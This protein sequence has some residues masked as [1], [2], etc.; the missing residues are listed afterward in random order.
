MS[1]VYSD[2]DGVEPVSAS[3]GEA[4]TN[5]ANY[6]TVSGC[7]VTY[8]GANMTFD[9]AAGMITHNGTVLNVAAQAG[10]GP[11]VADPDDPRW[12]WIGLDNTGSVVMV[13][14]TPAAS[15]TVP[16]LGDY[17]E[18]ALVLVT[19]AATIANDLTYKLDKRVMMT[20]E[21]LPDAWLPLYP[22]AAGAAQ[23]ALGASLGYLIPMRPFDRRVT[24]TEL[25][26]TLGGST[27]T[28]DVGIYS[29]TDYVTFT[30]VAST[31][32]L[33][34]PG[35]DNQHLNITDTVLDPG[36]VYYTAIS[37]SG[38][39][40]TIASLVG[41]AMPTGVDGSTAGYAY[42]RLGEDSHPLPATMTG[43]TTENA[44]NPLIAGV[45]SGGRPWT[46]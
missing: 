37:F 30:R 36:T 9:V 19:A 13:A 14:G 41:T 33:A 2:Q 8:S 5:I 6:N 22:P 44:D 7:A 23:S 31:G 35:T 43:M 18:I 29:T 24:I 15:P 28:I 4:A 1:R 26:V 32:S 42:V 12:T 17:V 16:V 20:Y 10:E 45:I 27:D 40:A 25:M 11:L 3:F 46:S 38:T 21:A 39:T 34:F